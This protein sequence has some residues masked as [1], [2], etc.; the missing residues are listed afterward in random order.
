[1]TASLHGQIALVTGGNRGIGQQISRDLAASGALVVVGARQ[2]AAAEAVV[3]QIKA[4]GGQA[5]AT[6]LDVTDAGQVAEAIDGAVA[7]HGKLDL[8][9][10]NAGIGDGGEL[11]WDMPVDDFWSVLE[12]NVR[13]PYL[14]SQAAMRHMSARRAGRI[15]DVG[16]LVGANPNPSAAPYATSKAALQRWNSCLAASAKEFGVSVFVI[17]P[18]LVATDMTNIPQF[19][20]VPADAWVPIEKCGELVVRL[21]SGEADVLSGRFVH[22]L[23]DLD[24]LIANADTIVAENLQ[25]MG[26]RSF[27][28]ELY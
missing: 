6:R 26:I 8:L 23:D 25:T 11:A 1:M 2:L 9:V 3:E 16:S 15:I 22:A 21:A 12:V 27:D 10:N 7:R 4:A 17:S 18:G 20:D 5:E 24:R 19:A 14:C 28:S 13:G